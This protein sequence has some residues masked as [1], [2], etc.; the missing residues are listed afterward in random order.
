MSFFPLT[1]QIDTYIENIKEFTSQNL[2]KLF[3]AEALQDQ[4]NWNIGPFKNPTA[5]IG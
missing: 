3:M 5:P 1:G 2:G 4:T